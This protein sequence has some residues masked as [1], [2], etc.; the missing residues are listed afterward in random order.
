M[1]TSIAFFY[2]PYVGYP[3]LVLICTFFL[4]LG[5][6]LLAVLDRWVNPIDGNMKKRTY[7]TDSDY[8]VSDTDMGE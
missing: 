8:A 6:I 7:M 2:S 3:F 5:L 4:F 1:S